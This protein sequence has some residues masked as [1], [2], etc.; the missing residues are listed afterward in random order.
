[1]WWNDQVSYILTPIDYVE[2]TTAVSTVADTKVT[3]EETTSPDDKT[4]LPTDKSE[5]DDYDYDDDSGASNHLGN[6]VGWCNKL[7]FH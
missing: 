3:T 5:E 6:N 7:I 4:K 2:P 1:M